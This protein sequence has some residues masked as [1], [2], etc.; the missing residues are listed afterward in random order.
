MDASERC[1][2]RR[3]RSLASYV[4]PA[5]NSTAPQTAAGTQPGSAC[6]NRMTSGASP[7]RA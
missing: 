7:L 6:T 3:L 4:A 2:A 1:I 5:H